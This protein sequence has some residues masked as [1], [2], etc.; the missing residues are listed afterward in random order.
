MQCDLEVAIISERKELPRMLQSLTQVE[1]HVRRPFLL[2]DQQHDLIE[3]EIVRSDR[4]EYN[5]ACSDSI[6]EDDSDDEFNLNEASIKIK[7][8]IT[9]LVY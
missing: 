2:S 9:T 4:Q 7:L 6:E 8:V 5:L 1:L 3:D